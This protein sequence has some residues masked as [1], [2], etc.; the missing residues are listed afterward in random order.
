MSKAR[1]DAV[2]QLEHEDRL[3]TT[4]FE[5]FAATLGDKWKHGSA[6][7]LLVQHLAVREAAKQL[8]A[9]T[10]STHDGLEELSRDLVGE[11]EERRR[12][13]DRLDEM[14]RGVQPTN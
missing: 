10:L 8:I 5:E 9:E 13:L 1:P 6:G 3:V 4:L 12:H 14:A 7:E 11:A 2:D